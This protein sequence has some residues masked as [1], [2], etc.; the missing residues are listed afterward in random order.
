MRN[1]EMTIDFRKKPTQLPPLEI[2]SSAEQFFNSRAS[3]SSRIS[4]GT[5]SNDLDQPPSP[6][7]L[8]SGHNPPRQRPFCHSSALKYCTS[9][10]LSEHLCILSCCITHSLA[11]SFACVL[12]FYFM[13]YIGA[14][15]SFS[16]LFWLDLMLFSVDT[17]TKRNS[18]YSPY[19]AKKRFW[20]WYENTA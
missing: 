11:S 10:P 3:Q 16:L 2:H 20:F 12:S 6:H 17:Y 5:D 8:S 4:D 1:W 18:W 13:F 19:L 9:L 14:Y 7:L 15:I